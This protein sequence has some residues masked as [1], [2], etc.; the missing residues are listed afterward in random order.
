MMTSD[1]PSALPEPTS[2]SDTW[3]GGQH[4]SRR[5]DLVGFELQP[6]P[7]RQ[8]A[9]YQVADHRRWKMDGWTVW[10]RGPRHT[11]LLFCGLSFM[12]GQRSLRGDS[13]LADFPPDDLQI[14]HRDAV[15]HRDEQQR[16]ERRHRQAANLRVAERL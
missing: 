10:V 15:Q 6:A 2:E 9:E 7:R 12:P 8:C 14:E 13:C 16:D 5:D 11:F 3:D 4:L 1:T